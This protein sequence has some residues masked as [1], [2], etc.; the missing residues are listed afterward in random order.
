MKPILIDWLWDGIWV[1]LLGYLS[2]V[3]LGE[4]LAAIFRKKMPLQL[5]IV[6]TCATYTAITWAFYYNHATPLSAVLPWFGLVVLGG[7]GLKLVAHGQSEKGIFTANAIVDF[8]K[9]VVAFS[10][11]FIILAALYSVLVADSRLPIIST[12]NNDIWSYSKFAKMTLSQPTG[13]N[14]V[15]FDL[16]RISAADQTPTSFM[17]LAGLAHFLGREVVDILFLGLILVLTMSITIVKEL[18]V[19][20][21]NVG[22]SLAYL[23]AIAWVTSSFYFYLVSNYFLAQLL[24]ICFFMATLL[25]VTHNE[26]N[27]LIQTATLSLLNY[28]MFMTF[29]ALFFPYMGVLLF[30][31]VMQAAFSRR[32][33]GAAFFTLR[34]ASIFFSIPISL[35][36]VCV[37]D[38]GHFKTMLSRMVELSSTNAGWPFNLL[39]P[40][41]LMAFP[42]TPIDSG[43]MIPKVMGYFAI[44]T[45]LS[46]LTH[47]AHKKKSLSAAQFALTSV[48]MASLVVYLCYYALKGASYQQWKFAGSVVMPL[49]FLP[50]TVVVSA[51]NG[52][53]RV[54][55]IAKHTLLIALIAMNVFVMNKLTNSSPV[56]L[57]RY[58]SL[59]QLMYYDQDPNVKTI[60]VDFGDDFTATMIAAQFINQKPL[61]LWSRSYYSEDRVED[62]SKLSRD[63]I[64]VTNS[65]SVFEN[66]NL[67]MLGELFV[68]IR[69]AP[70]LANEFLIKLNKPLPPILKTAG[71]SGQESFGR[72]NDGHKVVL[73]IP[74]NVEW[75]GMKLKI[76]GSPYL[77]SGIKGQRMSFSV[78]GSKVK[79]LSVSSESEIIIHFNRAM[80]DGGHVELIIDL[81]D[82]VSPSKFG[83]TD[84]RVLGF[85]FHTLEV[86]AVV[87]G[88]I[89]EHE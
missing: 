79:E 2:A 51:F 69:G 82:A 36:I 19:K 60:N 70:R 65:C 3:V 59:R 34:R 23:I 43:I 67:A 29:P 78:H 87:E 12:G 53:G 46:Y 71:L 41:A 42:V 66:K 18:C 61:A 7:M 24:G 54:N 8:L 27:F 76:K 86:K 88:G 16:L 68:I 25:V 9:P 13:N 49:S 45:L 14:I 4:G 10:I 50:I 32:N 55:S 56:D 44:L 15:N 84:T 73:N 22:K 83:S 63:D 40:F 31:A 5:G 38:L 62:Y 52:K 35:G 33:S 6:A 1:I 30:L 80:F 74:V 77:P 20:Y 47:R 81:P 48:F 17:F 57:P 39:H 26:E 85:G 75:K 72:W 11:L 28:L 58:A 89:Y 37:L 64:W 21:W